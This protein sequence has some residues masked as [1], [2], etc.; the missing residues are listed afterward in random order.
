MNTS[1]INQGWSPDELK[2]IAGADDLKISPFREDGITYGTPTWIW[3]VA[4]DGE[5]YVRAYHGQNSRWYQSALQQKA[6]RIHAVGMIW[7]V[8]FEPV[9]GALNNRIDE[10]YRTKY[11]TSSYLSSMISDQSKAATVRIVALKRV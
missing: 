1:E 4:L 5:L 7:D 6:G 2:K 11:K 8:L 9:E 3:N 10:V